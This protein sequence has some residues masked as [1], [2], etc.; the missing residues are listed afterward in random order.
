MNRRTWKEFGTRIN[1]YKSFTECWPG[2]G[3]ARF[4]KRRLGKIRRRAAREF[5]LEELFNIRP[6]LRGLDRA[7][8]EANWKTW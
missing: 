6:H 1:E 8:R 4:T 5:I 7:E 3:A 2:P